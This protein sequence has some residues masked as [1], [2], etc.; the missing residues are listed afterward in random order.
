MSSDATMSES[1]FS[2]ENDRD[3][4]AEVRSLLVQLASQV[5]NRSIENG[6][7]TRIALLSIDRVTR[8]VTMTEGPEDLD[9]VFQEIWGKSG[10]SPASK[11][12]IEALSRVKVTEE[13]ADCVICLEEFEVGGEATEMPCKHRFHSACIEKW[14][15]IHGSCPICRFVMPVEEV[16]D[17]NNNGGD[18]EPVATLVVYIRNIRN[19]SRRR[20]RDSMDEDSNSGPDSGD[21]NQ[22][23]QEE[24]DDVAVAVDNSSEIEDMEA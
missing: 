10:V 3:L 8:T 1:L 15:G 21:S 24:N 17:K 12:S 7:R 19:I 16:G 20:G 23:S 13:D 22:D 4:E 6:R 14:L 9:S 11:E 2:G 5:Q 18:G